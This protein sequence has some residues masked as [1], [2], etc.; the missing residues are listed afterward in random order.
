[1]ILSLR[2]LGYPL[3]FSGKTWQLVVDMVLF[4]V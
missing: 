4:H 2:G 1:M 3:G